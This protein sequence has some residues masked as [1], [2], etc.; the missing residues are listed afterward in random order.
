MRISVALCSYNGMPFIK[1]QLESIGRQTRL[2]DE[3]VV[4]DDA[5]TDSTLK[6]ARRFASTVPFP[7]HIEDN[8]LNLGTR[9]N[10]ERAIKLSK[11]DVIML[12]DQDDVWMPAKIA[13]L[14][15]VFD[16]QPH[17]GLAF[18]DLEI[19]NE[20][21]DQKRRRMWMAV[22]LNKR[23]QNQVNNGRALDVLLKGPVVTGAAMAFR[24]NFKNLIL[25]IPEN[26]ILL[27]DG[28]ISLLIAAVADTVCIDEPLVRYRYHSQQ[29]LGPPNPLL[30]AAG[31]NTRFSTMRD[32]VLWRLLSYADAFQSVH[33]RLA[34]HRHTYERLE[35][36][37]PRFEATVAHLHARG[38]LSERRVLRLP[39]ILREILYLR[40]H[41]YSLGFRSAAK[42]L[43]I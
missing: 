42:D 33:G 5:S 15:K 12:S 11:H 41:R 28:W 20:T 34:L 18:T 7:V 35:A 22:G 37:L 19:M 23:A 14:E 26:G 31:I 21:S 29:Q 10:F 43:V 17:V 13:R 2:P 32:R 1:E 38:T 25:P 6:E 39:V 16:E 3:L 8:K 27:H 24:S 9:K 40:Y 30:S 36:E 4:C